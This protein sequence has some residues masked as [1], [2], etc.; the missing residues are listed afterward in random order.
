MP[1]IDILSDDLTVGKLARLA[2]LT[3]RKRKRRTE[4]RC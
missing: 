2:K 3:R 1:K 4:K